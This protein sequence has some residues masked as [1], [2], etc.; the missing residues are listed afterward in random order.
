MSIK[1]TKVTIE[2][3]YPVKLKSDHSYFH[4]MGTYGKIIQVYLKYGDVNRLKIAEIKNWTGQAFVVSRKYL[5]ELLERDESKKIGVYFLIGTEG[6]QSSFY[7][8][9][10]EDFSSR[11]KNHME[12]DYWNKVILFVNKDEN[13]TKAHVQYL[14]KSLYRSLNEAKRVA[15]MNR[16]VPNKGKLSE[17]EEDTMREFLDNIIS[18]LGVLGYP[19]IDRP[20]GVS[21]PG[22]SKGMVTF[23]IRRKKQPAIVARMQTDGE[24]FVVLRGSQL[25]PETRQ[26]RE[27]TLSYP[28]INLRER[29]MREGN[30]VVDGNYLVL[31][32]DVSFTSASTSATFVLGRNSNGRTEWKTEDKRTYAEIEEDQLL[33]G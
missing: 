32:T 5:R 25:V 24:T 29:L 3:H 28:L 19:N 1:L 10:T 13:L 6:D 22:N 16:N 9:E 12:K 31:K 26:I 18:I 8:G 30:L 23:Y 17:A 11:I 15:L 4:L 7:I 27:Q 33:V 20:I 2:Q 14:E 21:E